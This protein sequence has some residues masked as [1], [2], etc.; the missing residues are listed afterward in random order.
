MIAMVVHPEIKSQSVA[1][2][3]RGDHSVGTFIELP[4]HYQCETEHKQEKNRFWLLHGA[5][6]RLAHGRNTSG[7]FV[8]P[9]SGVTGSQARVRR[10]GSQEQVRVPRTNSLGRFQAIGCQHGSHEHVP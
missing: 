2:F 4:G 3:I 10:T 8:N 6:F 9:N 1:I 7:E 5:I